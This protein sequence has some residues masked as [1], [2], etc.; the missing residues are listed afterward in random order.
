MSLMTKCSGVPLD[1][2]ALADNGEFEGYLSVFNNVDSY[3]EM[4]MPGA[5]TG[6][7]VDGA[8]KGRSV[9]LLWQHDTD[10]P[11]GVW[12][13]LAEDKKGLYAK[14][15]L[16]IDDSVQAKEAYG[17]LKA[18]AVDGLSIGYRV[19]EA[20]P[21]P[22][23]NNVLQLRKLDLMEGSIVTFPANDRAKVDSVKH[24][25][26]AGEVPTVR[27]CVV[28]R[29]RAGPRHRPLG[30]ADAAGNRRC[31]AAAGRSRAGD[32]L[33][34][35]AGRGDR[36]PHRRRHR[37]APQRPDHQRHGLRGADHDHRSD[38]DR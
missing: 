20:A 37:R 8:R 14:G 25:L 22:D 13:D 29:Q 21:H 2:K 3:G 12:K 24:I 34:P 18:G 28:D 19:I 16:L 38:D 11:I 7:L 31:P 36:N 27:L 10:R 33:R 32:A 30:E 17:L 9:K 26:A 1:V 4:V 35:G 6:S 23:K 15:Q 5:F